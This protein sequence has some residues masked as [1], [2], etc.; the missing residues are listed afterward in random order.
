MTEFWSP[1]MF[2]HV[3]VNC[4]S[5]RSHAVAA[6]PGTFRSSVRTFTYRRKSLELIQFSSISKSTYRRATGPWVESDRDQN[7]VKI[8]VSTDSFVRACVRA[9]VE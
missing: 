7:P 4:T 5:A 6:D 2:A 9:C 3:P 8:C 1:V